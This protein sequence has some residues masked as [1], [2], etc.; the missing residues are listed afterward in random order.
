MAQS[1][2]TAESI[3][4]E[5]LTPEGGAADTGTAQAIVEDF[6]VQ[7]KLDPG[8]KVTGQ[9]G[10]E[11]LGVRANISAFF[12]PQTAAEANRVFQGSYPE[13][14]II[15]DPQDKELYFRTSRKQKYRKLD[16]DIFTDSGRWRDFLY[17]AAEFAAYDAPIIAGEL[18]AFATTKHPTFLGGAV[19]GFAGAGGG[20]LVRQL[21]QILGGKTDAT[22]LE[23]GK[24]VATTGL[25]GAAGEAAS[26]PIVA[27]A[28]YAKGLPAMALETGAGR[29][30]SAQFRQGLPV[31]TPGQTVINP[32]IKKW[33]KMGAQFS[34]RMIQHFNKQRQEAMKKFRTIVEGATIN[35][36]VALRTAVDEAEQRIFRSLPGGV[37]PRYKGMTSKQAGRQLLKGV[38]EWDELAKG[39]VDVAYKAARNAAPASYDISNLVAAASQVLRGTRIG[40]KPRKVEGKLLDQYGDPIMKTVRET[41]RVGALTKEVR[42]AAELI[43]KMDPNLPTIDGVDAT[44]QLMALR[45]TLWDAKTP[46]PGDVFRQVNRDA[47]A[48]YRSLTKAMDNPVIDVEDARGLWKDAAAAASRRFAVLDKAV[49]GQILKTRVKGGESQ[50]AHALVTAGRQSDI[51]DLKSLIPGKRFEDLKAFVAGELLRDPAKI[52]SMDQ[53]V[54]RSLVGKRDLD[55]ITSVVNDV[56]RLRSSPMAKAFNDNIS[57]R[58]AMMDFL[59]GLTPSQTN[60]FIQAVKNNAP[61][62]QE[63]KRSVLNGIGDLSMDASRQFNLGQFN[64]AIKKFTDVGLFRKNGLWSKT[65]QQAI[66]DFRAYLNRV[67]GPASQDAGVSLMAAGIASPAKLARG[68]QGILGIV[69]E[70]VHQ[71]LITGGLGRFLTSKTG[72]RILRGSARRRPPGGRAAWGSNQLKAIMAATV[73]S[74]APEDEETE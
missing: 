31:V 46:A 57:G 16:P 9:P 34:P 48:L 74:M 39:Q 11:D 47:D 25:Y 7:Q 69:M 55:N 38:T 12:R 64:N 21:S 33:E 8:E 2:S 24:Q 68:E 13:G 56:A 43:G 23:V 59:S 26:K 14:D 29:A 17:D 5:F 19:R 62:M 65:E 63:M 3:V 49:I 66:N 53:D 51:D 60:A 73:A 50:L 37:Y 71:M 20:E 67:A 44:D 28:R 54:L 40:L 61:L 32:L 15:R 72:A 27:A 41:E 18:A 42:E 70:S 22:P 58:V 52:K 30:L 35:L 36:P 45:H 4:D 1:P 10:L 6:L